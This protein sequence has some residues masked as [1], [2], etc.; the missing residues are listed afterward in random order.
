[1]KYNEFE[2]GV[3]FERLGLEER[4]IDLVLESRNNIRSVL[5]GLLE[6]HLR[7]TG[8]KVKE[9]EVV[10]KDKPIS[11]EY[12]PAEHTIDDYYKAMEAKDTKAIK[13][14]KEIEVKPLDEIGALEEVESM[15][16][17]QKVSPFKDKPTSTDDSF[18]IK[19]GDNFMETTAKIAP[20]FHEKLTEVIKDAPEYVDA[21]VE[22]YSKSIDSEIEE[23][24]KEEAHHAAVGDAWVPS[25]AVRTTEVQKPVMSDPFSGFV[26]P[27]AETTAT[28]VE[29][30]PSNLWTPYTI[31]EEN[32]G[33]ES[34]ITQKEKK[35]V[36]TAD[37]DWMTHNW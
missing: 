37:P 26:T 32:K 25:D 9:D 22:E 3:L 15:L 16:N 4:V 35:I 2:L 33:S 21:A 19:A 28:T 34:Q 7:Y 18:I 13:E 31:K 20:S 5:E 6:R 36:R 17:V 8:V 29:T 12:P 11:A 10:I 24:E 27:T 14:I 1:M 30:T 23:L